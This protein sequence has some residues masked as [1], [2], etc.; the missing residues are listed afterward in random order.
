MA[1]ALAGVLMAGPVI[2]QPIGASAGQSP[3][4][5]AQAVAGARPLDPASLDALGRMHH[6]YLAG[7]RFAELARA[8]GEARPIRELGDR[9]TRDRILLNRQLADYA[10][11]FGVTLVEL[12]PYSPISGP[13]SPLAA[14]AQLDDARLRELTDLAASPTTL[15]P[16]LLE[17]LVTEHETSLHEIAVARAHAGDPALRGLLAR[18]IPILEQDFTIARDLQSRYTRRPR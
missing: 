17:T 16:A 8:R 6:A 2:A 10:T 5:R 15:T 9:I 1:L 18:A 13:S 12:E 4:R 11:P 14:A 3:E 7:L